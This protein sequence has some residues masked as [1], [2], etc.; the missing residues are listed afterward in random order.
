MSGVIDLPDFDNMNIEHEAWVEM[1][2][3]LATRLGY[4]GTEPLNEDTWHPFFDQVKHWGETLV[5]LRLEQD[6]VI[7]QRAAHEAKIVATEGRSVRA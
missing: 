7:R 2:K 1:C 3:R 4:N 5:A 6:E